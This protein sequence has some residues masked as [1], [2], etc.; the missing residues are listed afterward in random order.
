M[1]D[2][3]EKIRYSCAQVA[4]NATHIKIKTDKICSYA[5]SLPLSEGKTMD[6]LNHYCADPQNTLAYFFVLDSI[7][8]GSGYFDVLRKDEGKTGYFTI[9]SRLKKELETKNNFS[10]D[11]LVSLTPQ[12]CRRIFDQFSEDVL[13]TELM[14]LFSQALNELGNFIIK[15]YATNFDLLIKSAQKSAAKLVELL[16]RMKMYQDISN[17]KG[18]DVYFYKRAQITVSDL[19]LAFGGKGYGEFEDIEHLTIFAD[20]LVPHVLRTDGIIE[21]SKSL[22]E[23]VDSKQI[24]PANSEEEIEI[25]AV[26]VHTVELIK[27]ALQKLKLTVTS[28]QLDQILWNRGQE[29]KYRALPR[30]ITPSIFY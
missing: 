4:L 1:S 15:E 7:N 3:F 21:Y 12:E 6:T 26:A 13:I 20:N 8:F 17:Y 30:H 10:P 14:N 11:Y 23:K 16:S 5:H 25:R 29:A 24:L 18:F 9:A 2:I 28:Q 19:F 27:N 22:R